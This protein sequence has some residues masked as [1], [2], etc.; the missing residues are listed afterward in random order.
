MAITRQAC[1]FLDL[2]IPWRQKYLAFLTLGTY[3]LWTIEPEGP[4]APF[5]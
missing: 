1:E 4:D 3:Y 2:S 5:D